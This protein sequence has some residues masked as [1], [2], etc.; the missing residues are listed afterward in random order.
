MLI[1]GPNIFQG[2]YKNDEATEGALQDGWLHTGDLGR[3]DE[4]GFLYITGRKKDIIIT[5]GG[6]NITPANLENGL[7]Q[8]RFISQAVVVGDRRPYLVALIT[9]DPEEAPALAQQL[10]LED[11][12]LASLA[13]EEK[14][15]AEVQA[16]ID[17]VNS[18]V[19]PVEQIKR[20]AILD[21]DLSQETGELTPT[22]KVKRNVVHEKF[23]DVVEQIYEGCP[24]TSRWAQALGSAECAARMFTW[25]ATTP[26][27][28]ADCSS[29]AGPARRPFAIARSS[30]RRSGAALADNLLAHALLA[31]EMVL[32]LTLFGPQP[33]AWLWIGSQVDY[34]TGYVTAG[35]ATIMLGCLA[36]LM[37]TMAAA[38]RVDHAWKLVRR[39][40]GHRQERGALERI[41]ATSVAVAVVAF[42]AWFL[43]VEGPGPSLAPSD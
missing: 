26:P 10:E 2:Y 42:T 43:I 14:V 4:D 16:A 21:H 17:D 36:S 15:R 37:L 40:A 23:A 5:A 9:L 27:T 7:K 34:L 29:G 6:K 35:I 12:D 11:A 18:H 39:A 33:L 41:F 22:L 31:V 32:C 25:P 28:R 30:R 1:K 8:N 3:L 38:K 19:G 13:K 24:L 20:F